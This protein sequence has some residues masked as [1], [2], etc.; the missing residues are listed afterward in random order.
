MKCFT[1]SNNK[2][3]EGV[4]S[5]DKKIKLKT[6]AFSINMPEDWDTDSFLT[7]IKSKDLCDVLLYCNT[8]ITEGDSNSS[9]FPSDCV[10]LCCKGLA[11]DVENVW[12]SCLE[13]RTENLDI[14]YVLFVNSVLFDEKNK[15]FIKNTE[16]SLE[17][18]KKLDK[19]LEDEHLD[20]NADPEEFIISL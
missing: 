13:I 11:L 18:L 16:G 20:I 9:V 17:L 5:T 1:Y 2:L 14:Y 6:C 10:L 12:N 3:N 8:K 4:L 15:I 19:S 7:L